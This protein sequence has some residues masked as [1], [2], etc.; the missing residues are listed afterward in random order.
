MGLV[1]VIGRSDAKWG[2]R[3]VLIVQP[4]QGDVLDSQ[5]LL[6]SLRGKVPDWW[7]PDQVLQI[8]SMPLAATGKIDKNQLR[9]NYAE[10]AIPAPGANR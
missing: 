5:A 8:D 10:R 1:A 4:R 9:A 3:P 6:R 2:E 7:I